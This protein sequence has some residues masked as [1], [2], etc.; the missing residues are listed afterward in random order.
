MRD[1]DRLARCLT[2]PPEAVFADE[3]RT[4]SVRHGGGD[5][6][7]GR[8]EALRNYKNALALLTGLA[9]LGGVWPVMEVT[10]VLTECADAVVSAAVRFLFRAGQR[11]GA[12][13]IVRRGPA[14]KGLRL[15]R[16][17]DGQAWAPLSSTTRATST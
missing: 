6:H 3:T 17:R 16:A 7:G 14:G 15:L 2:A 8:Q 13:A 5:E 12:V 1:C 10:R 4:L 9:D 11:A